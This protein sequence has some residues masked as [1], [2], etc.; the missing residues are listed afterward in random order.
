MSSSDISILLQHFLF[1]FNR[2]QQE[3][4]P[5]PARSTIVAGRRSHYEFRSL[6]R[7]AQKTLGCDSSTIPRQPSRFKVAFRTTVFF[8]Q[9]ISYFSN[10]SIFLFR[11]SASR[12]HFNE[13][14]RLLPRRPLKRRLTVEKRPRER[15]EFEI[16]ERV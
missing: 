4:T 5:S 11:A 14:T 1:F 13:R 7:T 15:M 8:L 2:L 3:S 16:V 10:L 6:P 12:F 9:L